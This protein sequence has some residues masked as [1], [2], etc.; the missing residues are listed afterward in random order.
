MT[1]TKSARRRQ[2]D[3]ISRFEFLSLRLLLPLAL[4]ALVVLGWLFT[5]QTVQEQ[6]RL[7]IFADMQRGQTLLASRMQS[8]IAYQLR[9]GKLDGVRQQLESLGN[10]PEIKIALLENGQGKVISAMDPSAT[11]KDA[12]SIDP[13]ATLDV[14]TG[15]RTWVSLE[16]NLV[17]SAYPVPHPPSAGTN[18]QLSA[19]NY[20]LFIVGDPAYMLSERTALT[21]EW[22]KKTSWTAAALFLVAWLMMHFLVSR[23]IGKLMQA[24]VAFEHGVTGA[25]SGLSGND[26]IGRLGQ[27]FDA[28]VHAH[29]HATLKMRK[30]LQAVEQSAASVIITD[31]RGVIEFV[32]PAFTAITGY[33]QEE[34]IGMKTSM[35]SAGKT[36]PETYTDMW[37]TIST[38]GTWRGEMLNRRKNGELYWD[39]ITISPV[40]D[41]KNAITGFVAIQ[42]DITSRK[43]ADLALQRNEAIQRAVFDGALD[44]IVL[45][46]DRGIITGWNKQAEN[47]FGWPQEEAVGRVLSEMLIPQ[48]YREA[49]TLGVQHYLADGTAKVLNM[50]IEIESLHRDGHE[51]PIELAI[52]PVSIGEKHLFSAF[53]RDITERK[54]AEN[55]L[56]LNAHILNSISEGVAVTD[57]RQMF[58]FINPAF[59]AITGYTAEEVIGKSP[60]LLSSG[61][62]E[63]TFY[64]DM[65]GNITE[66]GRW[67]GEIID[68]RKNGESY[69][70]WLSI[71]VLKDAQGA[72]THYVSVFADI[73]ERK[74]VERRITHMAQHDFLTGL[75]NRMLLLD[76]MG[77]ALSHARRVGSKV[78]VM[79]LDLD[80][81]K[82]IN[83]MLGH[84]IG[85]KLLQEVAGRISRISRSGDTVCRLGGDEFV[86]MLTE[87]EKA[88]GASGIAEKLL[89]AVAGRIVIDG[90]EV[91][92]TTS[93]GI[94]LFPDDG[95]EGNEL[96]QQADAAMYHAKQNGRN[97]YHFF[98][99]EMNRRALERISIERNLRHAL[100]R[101]EFTLYYQ[102]QVDLGS[103]RLVGAEALLRWKDPENGEMI[104]PTRFI[105]VAEENGMIA[106]IGEW[107]LRESCRQMAEWR[108]SGLPE[109][110]VSV[111]LSAVQFRQKDLG[112]KVRAI[113]NQYGISPSS[114]E[115]EITETAVMQD[116]E[117]AIA[118]LKEMKKMGVQLAMDDFG[119]G[120]SSLS[121]LKQ[122]PIDKLKIDKSFVRDI[123]HDPDDAAIVSTIISMARNLKLKVIAEGVE[124]DRQLAFL[125]QHGCDL[126]QGYYFAP[127]VPQDEFSAYF[128]RNFHA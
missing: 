43:E 1:A 70:E 68:R 122:L 72:I 32:N 53:V 11:G 44:G 104:P 119:T 52:T 5:Y 8:S 59:T 102:P 92:I 118:L 123:A 96:L 27:A 71:S 90:H 49:H 99:S 117:A 36:P 83:D 98:T 19:R 25:F 85:D 24:V 88:E 87:L 15:G 6:D 86:L 106:S 120:Y 40:R 100:E 20:I 30:L 81:F 126:A 107:V 101:E 79:F 66:S 18:K 10:A 69:P 75:P 57:A 12:T 62:M 50:R 48:R 56:L 21:Q 51:F 121:H 116:A 22:I 7:E 13:E 9:Q 26:E 65:W 2:Q 28:M 115:L 17:L 29:R 38:G 63:R 46:N 128:K 73:S 89:E 109:I 80:K 39:S 76:R 61:L 23:R 103:M 113:L 108:K 55:K 114:L 94:A 127:P 41:E 105:S 82:H 78:A 58:C 74:A 31:P 111:N 91:E 54:A 84:V 37:N 42:E 77:Q 14:P 47:I 67:Q 35:L 3:L 45:M 95:K 16:R 64:G 97:N 112:E 124:T 34:A 125:N 33:T 4:L 110:S 60:K 93:I